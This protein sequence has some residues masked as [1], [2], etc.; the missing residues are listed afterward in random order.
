MTNNIALVA[1]IVS[2]AAAGMISGLLF[3][4]STSVMKAL[5]RMPPAQGMAAMNH[6][7]VAIINPVFLLFFVG[8]AISCLAVLVTA[9]F[10]SV[11]GTP[12]RVAGAIVYLI[13][14]IVVTAAV[15]VPMNDRLAALDPATTEGTDYWATYLVRWTNWNH[16]RTVGGLVGVVLMALGF[17]P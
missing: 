13:T 2:I 15:N 5:G 17:R 11:A 12:W 6:M 3:A 8:S 9:P 1:T 14:V 10:D 16:V 7:N 4:F